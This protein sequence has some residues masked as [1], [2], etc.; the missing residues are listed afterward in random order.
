MRQTH[1]ALLCVVTNASIPVL[2]CSLVG[3]SPKDEYYSKKPAALVTMESLVVKKGNKE[4]ERQKLTSTSAKDNDQ[5]PQGL[6]PKNL[7][8]KTKTLCQ[9]HVSKIQIVNIN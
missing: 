6:L 3:L 9:L 1:S 8:D 2:C 7:F 5:Q 4:R